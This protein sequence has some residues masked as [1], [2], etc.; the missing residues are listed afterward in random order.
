MAVETWRKC[1]LA[2]HLTTLA[3]TLKDL[4]SRWVRIKPMVSV[5]KFG[6]KAFQLVR[7]G[8]WRVLAAVARAFSTA[9]LPRSQFKVL[10][11]TKISESF[12]VK[13]SAKALFKRF[14]AFTVNMAAGGIS[15]KVREYVRSF[16][17]S[18]QKNLLKA[19]FNYLIEG[20]LGFFTK[21]MVDFA[22]P[23]LLSGAVSFFTGGSGALLSLLP[24]RFNLIQKLSQWV[25]QMSW[26]RAAAKSIATYVCHWVVRPLMEYFGI[27]EM[28]WQNGGSSVVASMNQWLIGALDHALQLFTGFRF[29]T[30]LKYFLDT[31]QGSFENTFGNSN[32]ANSAKT[33]ILYMFEA[34]IPMLQNAGIFPSKAT[35]WS[36]IGDWLCQHCQTRALLQF[37]FEVRLHI[38]HRGWG[39]WQLCGGEQLTFAFDKLK[40][41]WS[42]RKKKEMVQNGKVSVASMLTLLH[43]LCFPCR[44]VKLDGQY[45]ASMTTR[46]PEK[47]YVC[48]SILACWVVTQMK[49]CFGVRFLWVDVWMFFFGG[50]YLTHLWP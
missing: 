42:G 2:R 22:L 16:M 45:H 29:E 31:L 21:T 25:S 4:R 1:S 12:L 17:A 50:S 10:S 20:V 18:L 14:I 24:A 3:V 40:D 36:R 39:T 8:M 48:G 37:C 32:Q 28:L 41:T 19:P 47:P 15:T 46:K 30:A 7:S 9:P 49:T 43:P 13:F 27:F 6:M 5:A 23:K 44:P 33:T 38:N 34:L 35:V 11:R 26:V